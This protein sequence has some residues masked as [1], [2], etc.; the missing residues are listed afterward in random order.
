MDDDWRVTEGPAIGK[1]PGFE[2]SEVH[3][4]LRFFVTGAMSRSIEARLISPT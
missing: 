1:E 3:I 2:V 4:D